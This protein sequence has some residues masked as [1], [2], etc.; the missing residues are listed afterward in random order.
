[1]FPKNPFKL[2]FVTAFILIILS[3]ILT[4][5]CVLGI[6]D[7]GPQRLWVTM[8][9]GIAISIIAAVIY[10]IFTDGI[11]ECKKY[12]LGIWTVNRYVVELK[13]LGE[14][15]KYGSLPIFIQLQDEKYRQWSCEKY[16]VEFGN[17][18]LQDKYL[19]YTKEDML[20]RNKNR[21]IEICEN[22]ILNFFPYISFER[23]NILQS[24]LNSYYI[25]N[26][27]YSKVFEMPREYYIYNDYNNQKDIGESIY[28]IH[29]LLS[30][31]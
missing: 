24:V 18:N 11:S 12:K 26:K 30:K 22:L 1:M 9:S 8:L 14:E 4:L 5:F 2:K 23:F 3:T 13:K 19:T 7:K 27:L 25:R 15:C 29:H 31:L 10:Y 16:S 6:I 20:E 28:K 17:Q 21:I